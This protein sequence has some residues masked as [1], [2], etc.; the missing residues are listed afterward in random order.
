MYTYLG[1]HSFHQWSMMVNFELLL[2]MN[3]QLLKLM[4]YNLDLSFLVG[5]KHHFDAFVQ[6]YFYALVD[7]E[8]RYLYK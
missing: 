7:D 8:E 4:P 2:G 3:E 1:W 5:L 6:F